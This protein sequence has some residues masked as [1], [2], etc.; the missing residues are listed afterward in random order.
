MKDCCVMFEKYQPANYIDLKLKSKIN[1]E[2]DKIMP[3]MLF[4][5]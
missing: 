3:K 4:W 5:K 1:K 2:W